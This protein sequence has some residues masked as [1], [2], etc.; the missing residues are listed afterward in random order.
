MSWGTPSFGRGNLLEQIVD[1]P[2]IMK[3]IPLTL[4]L[5]LDALEVNFSKL[6][7]TVPQ[8]WEYSLFEGKRKALESWQ[9]KEWKYKQEQ[10]PSPECDCWQN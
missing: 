2:E 6:Y 8:S 3:K 10:S 5:M 7:T 9:K 4:M 1:D